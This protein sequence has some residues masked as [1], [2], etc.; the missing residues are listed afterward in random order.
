VVQESRDRHLADA[1]LQQVRR[2]ALCLR[3]LLVLTDGW[4]AYPNSIRRAF[5]QKVKLT[6]GLGRAC[7]QVWPELHIGTVIKRTQN[8]R[9]VEITRQVAYGLLE[10]AEKLLH[11]SR[12]RM[13]LNTAFIERLNGAFRERLASFTR[14]SRHAARRL[15][16]LEMGMYLI[17]CSYK[18]CFAHHELSKPSHIGHRI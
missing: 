4:S 2:C 15:K 11:S 9:V 8:K 14:T 18:F 6:P 3:P 7:L 17:G 5:R 1:L 10:H 13:V 16:A 12:G